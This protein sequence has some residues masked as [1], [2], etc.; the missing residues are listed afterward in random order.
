MSKKKK[1]FILITLLIFTSVLGVMYLSHLIWLGGLGR[2]VDYFILESQARVLA[3]SALEFKNSIPVSQN[4]LT[5][6]LTIDG[7][8][9]SFTVIEVTNNYLAEGRLMPGN[10]QPIVVSLNVSK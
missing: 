7:V 3:E 6:T 10:Y 1:G 8:S 4:Y 9:A 2:Q 5:Q